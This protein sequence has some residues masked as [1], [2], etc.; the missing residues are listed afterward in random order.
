M[1]AKISMNPNL[2]VKFLAKEPSE[3][4]REDIIY[5]CRENEIKFINFH[6]CGWDGKL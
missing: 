2:L 3:F 1:N 4:T 5:Y 6:Y